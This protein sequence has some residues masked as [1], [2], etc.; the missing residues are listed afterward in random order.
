MK[1]LLLIV[2]VFAMLF[3]SC[4][5]TVGIIYDESTPL[6][7]SSWFNITNFGTVTAYN[8]LTVNWKSKTVS[9]TMVQIPAG[10]TLLEIDISS[11]VGNT[12]YTGKGMLL[13]YNFQPG[14]QYLF[15]VSRNNESGTI[16]VRVYAYDIGEKIGLTLGAM[17][18]HFVEFV[19]FLNSNPGGTTILN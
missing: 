13:R 5:T 4:T 1:K 9:P 6:E 15:I 14:K 12:V 18:P 19:Y 17:E 2:T 16:G 8:G 3:L 7:Q 11:N 10:N